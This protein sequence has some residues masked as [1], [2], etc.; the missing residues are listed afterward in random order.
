VGQGERQN[1]W[2]KRRSNPQALTNGIDP[3]MSMFSRFFTPVVPS[4][5]SEA[6]HNTTFLV[7]NGD[8]SLTENLQSAAG[9]ADVARSD[10]LSSKLVSA[11]FLHYYCAGA[12]GAAGP[13][14]GQKPT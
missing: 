6:L 12:Q 4:G 2:E 7:Q 9:G 3:G 11:L 5:T 10:L 1:S 8:K 14:K 13:R